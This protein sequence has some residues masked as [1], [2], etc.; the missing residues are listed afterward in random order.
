MTPLTAETG[1]G[2]KVAFNIP[3][4]GVSRLIAPQWIDE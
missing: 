3:Q 2:I 1:Y 4:T